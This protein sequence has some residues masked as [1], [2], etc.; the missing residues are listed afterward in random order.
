M[1]R[2][3]LPTIVYVFAEP[4][5]LFDFGELKKKILLILN[6]NRFYDFDSNLQML[7]K[8]KNC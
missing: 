6:V 7:L 5:K 1:I 3:C 4:N 8:K 2:P